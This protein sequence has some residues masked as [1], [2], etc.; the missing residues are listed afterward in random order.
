VSAGRRIRDPRVWLGLGVTVLALWLSFRDVSWSAL[1]RDVSRANWWLLVGVSIPAYMWA[2]LLRAQRWRVLARGVAEFET[3]SALRATAVGF[4]V[5]N[6]LPLRVGELVRVWWL[7]REIKSSAS[8]LLGTLILERVI[9]VVFLLGI[10]SV[11]IGNQVGRGL[12]LAAAAAPLLAVLTLRRWPGAAVAVVERVAARVVSAARAERLAGIVAS[13]A[14]GVAS[15]RG[16][17]DVARVAVTTVGLW[18]VASVIPF[19]AT[20]A[21]LGIELGGPAAELRAAFITL[22]WVGAAV[23]L[24]SAPGFFGTYHAACVVALTPLGVSREMSLAVGTLAHAVFWMA[25]TAFGLIALRLGGRHLRD[26]LAGAD[27]VE[28]EPR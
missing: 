25:T 28:S 19:W 16:R 15:L 7:A 2:L 1:A 10:A 27:S 24:P 12:L 6:L 22:V 4:M 21:S 14:A 8:A 9:D 23:A 5:N 20:L 18:A 3:A 26:A 17:G 11:V 13:V